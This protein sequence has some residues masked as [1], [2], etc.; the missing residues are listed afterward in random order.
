MN[1]HISD[2]GNYRY[3]LTRD[4][5]DPDAYRDEIV[6]VMLN[7]STADAEKDDPTI[8]R[9]KGFCEKWKVK[10]FRVMNLYAFRATNPD[11]MLNAE[12]PV[13]PENDTWLKAL[14]C[15]GKVVIC[16]WGTKAKPERCRKVVS[17]LKANGCRL[18]CLGVTKDGFP[19]H[20]LYIPGN[21]K[22]LVYGTN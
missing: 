2:C 21:Q 13:G 11:D 5:P 1:A 7:P 10:G 4:N 15:P 9:L 17:L 6:F 12:D 16:A 8:R 22:P 20:P 14:T 3:W 19:K 18:F